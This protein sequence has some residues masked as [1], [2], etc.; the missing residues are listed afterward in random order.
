[1]GISPRLSRS[2]LSAS[3]SAQI[4]SW[5]SWAKQAPVVS[6]TYPVPIT[7][8]FP[9]R[10]LRLSYRIRS[11]GRNRGR[12]AGSIAG[13]CSLNAQRSG[14]YATLR[15]VF[16]SEPEFFLP[17]PTPGSTP[18][19]RDLPKARPRGATSPG[20]GQAAVRRCA[21]ASGRALSS[22]LLGHHADAGG[23]R[24]H[25]GTVDVSEVDG[26]PLRRGGD[27][28]VVV[29]SRRRGRGE[30][31]SGCPGSRRRSP[32]RRRHRRAC[33]PRRARAAR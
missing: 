21:T 9:I 12:P 6:P 3:M 18:R 7:A 27:R 2:T 17:A 24:R 28:L 19:G 26:S 16:R 8:I 25:R 33:R 30:A 5:P 31:A 23:R 20:G 1:M 13:P 10:V 29:V 22:P 4:T 32:V 11:S 15:R 14:A